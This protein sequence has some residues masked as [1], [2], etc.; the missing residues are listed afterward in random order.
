MIETFFILQALFV[1]GV[2]LYHLVEGM[3]RKML[4]SGVHHT[5]E[6]TPTEREYRRQTCIAEEWDKGRFSRM[7][8]YEYVRYVV[9]LYE[10]RDRK[11]PKSIEDVLDDYNRRR[12]AYIEEREQKRRYEWWLYKNSEQYQIDIERMK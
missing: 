5:P 7:G 10:H 3:G 11:S 6:D 2:C 12:Q 8:E 4:P 9:W 1:V